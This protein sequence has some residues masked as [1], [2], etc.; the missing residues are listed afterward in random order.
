MKAK[1][2]AVE[3]KAVV[4]EKVVDRVKEK[5]MGPA[6]VEQQSDDELSADS[7][8]DNEDA[9]MQVTAERFSKWRH[10]HNPNKDHPWKQPPEPHCDAL[11]VAELDYMT[12]QPM[13][14]P[15]VLHRWS[16]GGSQPY[17]A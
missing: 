17:R 7:A 15:C 10:D 16:C 4:K 6:V 14:D 3:A 11:V 13:D 5:I 1:E 2:K 9:L 8:T 12:G